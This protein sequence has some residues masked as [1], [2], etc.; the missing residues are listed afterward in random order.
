[1]SSNHWKAMT[2][3][4]DNDTSVI[5]GAGE[6]GGWWDANEVSTLLTVCYMPVDKTT[7]SGVSGDK[8]DKTY[9]IQ[10][11]TILIDGRNNLPSIFYIIQGGSSIMN[12]RKFCNY[13]TAIVNAE[14]ARKNNHDNEASA[15]FE[16]NRIWALNRLKEIFHDEDNNLERWM[17]GD[18][19]IF[20]MN[21]SE[22]PMS[23]NIGKDIEA[24]YNFLCFCYKL[25]TNQRISD[26]YRDY[27][28]L[29]ITRSCSDC[30]EECWCE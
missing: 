22:Q 19:C 1:M 21:H 16:Q 6:P 9:T 24:L 14:N 23:V 12:Y 7:I 29:S 25:N 26:E 5:A 17:K 28:A 4:G 11:I 10:T 13:L 18:C 15:T 27:L 8:Y 3:V 2:G 30:W 20:R